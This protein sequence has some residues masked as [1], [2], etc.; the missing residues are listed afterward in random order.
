MKETNSTVKKIFTFLSLNNAK[1]GYTFLYEGKPKVCEDCEYVKV[2]HENLTPH[3][4]YTVASVKEKQ[5]SCQVFE[6]DAR[7]VEV[8]P[9][10]VEGAV[11]VHLAIPGALIRFNPQPC[12]R[13]H[14]EK[15]NLCVPN[16]L[17]EG[18]ACRVMELRERFVCPRTGVQL[19]VSLLSQRVEEEP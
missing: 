3:T 4:A 5:V 10:E 12:S 1:E 16:A 17:V 14:C 8:Q 11:E 15:F 19:Q 18:A 13:L 6:G 2:C 9:A 7:L